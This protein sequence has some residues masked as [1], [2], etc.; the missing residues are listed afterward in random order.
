MQGPI[1]KDNL[2]EWAIAT[3]FTIPRI[4]LSNRQKANCKICGVSLL[5]G[6]GRE[7]YFL[8]GLYKVNR[9]FLCRE[10]FRLI[11]GL[12]KKYNPDYL[13]ADGL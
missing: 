6:E 5:K 3:L 13:N 2:G 11:S 4:N 8:K 9:C 12:I 1:G 10:D 7:V